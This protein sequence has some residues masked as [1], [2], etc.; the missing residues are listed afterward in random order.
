MSSP[1]ANMSASLAQR[2]CWG[3]VPSPGCSAA[4]SRRATPVRTDF[5]IQPVRFDHRANAGRSRNE[6]FPT[7]S[8]SPPVPTSATLNPASRTACDM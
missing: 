4:D 2:V 7:N 8:S 6:V 5:G 1:L 3:I